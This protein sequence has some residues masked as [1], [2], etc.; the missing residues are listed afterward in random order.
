MAGRRQHTLPKFLQSGFASTICKDRVKVWCY[1]KG[2]IGNEISTESVGFE[3][4]FYG[5]AQESNL[6]N[7][8]TA[9]EGE[10]YVPLI[11]ELR[12]QNKVTAVFDPRIPELVAHLSLRTRALRESI[13]DSALK[14][15]EVVETNL[16]SEEV[17]QEVFTHQ[18][19]VHLQAEIDKRGIVQE[20]VFDML[21][22]HLRNQLTEA[23]RSIWME[24][25]K[26][27]ASAA[28]SVGSNAVKVGH[29][30]A[31]ENS[32][33][34]EAASYAKLNWHLML[35]S[36]D[37]LLGD[38]ACITELSDRKFIPVAFPGSDVQRIYLPIDARRVLV[39]SPSRSVTELKVSKINKAIARCSF[40]FF[41]SSRE[42]P[43]DSHLIEHLGEWSGLLSAK[44]F[45][46][47]MKVLQ[48]KL[49][50]QFMPIGAND[51]T[52]VGGSQ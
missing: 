42:L 24:K 46:R 36:E 30:Q 3:N 45:E 8:I 9:I 21:V 17:F 1:R 50:A 37:L 4:Y 13:K 49:F 43:S 44:D 2:Q 15:L 18:L 27:P 41:L 52:G 20:N 7:Q 16:L 6:D 14:M 12:L 26:E 23:A 11:N 38:T 47:E 5:S 32:L 35:I 25:I 40:E 28:R 29:N 31:L 34:Q 33:A 10:K 51:Y 19:R 22:A 39:G 48:K